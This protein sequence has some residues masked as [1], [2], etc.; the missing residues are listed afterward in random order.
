MKDR[1]D[2]AL[3]ETVMA[4]AVTAH[5]ADTVAF[6][7]QHMFGG[8]TRGVPQ[9]VGQG[10]DAESEV[11]TSVWS[12]P[13]RVPAPTEVIMASSARA[14]VSAGTR[15]VERARVGVM[16]GALI[17]TVLL[18][19]VA[20]WLLAHRVRAR[21]LAPLLAPEKPAVIVAQ[22]KAEAN[23]AMSDVERRRREVTAVNALIAGDRAA[24]LIHYRELATRTGDATLQRVVVTLERTP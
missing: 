1:R 9:L 7:T 16:I 24:A 22:A 18:G 15:H 5:E 2:L 21:A 3:D 19:L 12:A 11:M 6:D 20:T 14:C 23:V 8:V 10:A 17:A 13:G 4:R